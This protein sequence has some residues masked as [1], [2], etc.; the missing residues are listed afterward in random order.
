MKTILLIHGLSGSSTTHW[1]PWFIRQMQDRGVRV[2]MPSLP[3][4]WFPKYTQWVA[5]LEKC[6]RENL[7]EQDLQETIVV[8]HSLGCI[9]ALHFLEKFKLTHPLL[10]CVFITGFYPSIAR[11]PFLRSFHKDPLNFEYLKTICGRVEYIYTDNDWLGRAEDTKW[12]RDQLPG[13]MTVFPGQGHFYAM[14]AVPEI[15]EVVENKFL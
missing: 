11:I 10:G 3:R 7:T 6:V 4:R 8:A 12:V 9:T 14:K 1:Y 2:I 15:V 5:M 13:A